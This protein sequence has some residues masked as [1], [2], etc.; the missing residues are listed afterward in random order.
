MRKRMLNGRKTTCSKC[1]KEVE[2]SRK[3]QRYCKYCHAEN[4][5]NTR[6]PHSLL[7]NIDRLKANCRSCTKEL[8]KRS[9]T[10]KLPCLNCGEKETQIHHPDYTNPR[11]FYWLCRICHLELHKN[12]E[13]QLK[14]ESLPPITI[15]LNDK[16]PE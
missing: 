8:L 4:M 12:P 13:L 5:R 6:K 9:N 2:E 1:G 16:L 10:P 11:I 15:I 3:G 14:I 7:E